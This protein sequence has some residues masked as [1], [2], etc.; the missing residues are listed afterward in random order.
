MRVFLSTI[1]K[2]L[3]D[4]VD[5]RNLWLAPWVI[6][7]YLLN[8]TTYKKAYKGEYPVRLYPLF[9]DRTAK[10]IFDPHYIYQAYWATKKIISSG[11][12]GCHVDIS[13]NLSFVIQLNALLPVIQLEFRPPEIKLRSYNR[14]SGD[15]LAL[16]FPDRSLY[17][18]TCLHVIE[19][20][21]LG[22]YGD[23]IDADGCWKGL[24][25]LE[26]VIAPGGSLYLSVPV[27]KPAVCFNANYLFRASDI[28]IRLS[29]LNLVDFSYVDDSRTLVEQGF[30]EDT[31]RMN[32]ALGLFHF[33][34]LA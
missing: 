28:V 27:G 16:P 12:T 31:I 14:I 29:T 21:G 25:E 34:R 13:S 1:L 2:N 22:R 4:L 20:I 8:L 7:V 9:F 30:M 15:I 5:P 6:M 3:K 33:K 18:V 17:S 24:L 23:P 19:H 11:F 32:Y 26:R 10:N